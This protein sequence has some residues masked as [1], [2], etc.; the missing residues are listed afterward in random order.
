MP[1]PITDQVVRGERRLPHGTGKTVALRIYPRVPHA[2]SRSGCR[3][4]T[5]SGHGLSGLPKMKAGD[6][7]NMTWCIASPDAM[8]ALL[9]SLCQLLGRVALSLNPKSVTVSAERWYLAVKNARLVR[10]ATVTDKKRQTSLLSRK[11]ASMQ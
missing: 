9:V 2:E 10:F 11:V 8:Q 7:L 1:R 4:L 6:L 3:P 5:T